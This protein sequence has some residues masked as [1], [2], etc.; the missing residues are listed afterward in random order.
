MTTKEPK[1]P[2]DDGYLAYF[3]EGTLAINPYA[4]GSLEHDEWENGFSLAK[5]E[6]ED[7]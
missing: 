7:E 6:D 2:E 4:K 5:A 1:N 3:M